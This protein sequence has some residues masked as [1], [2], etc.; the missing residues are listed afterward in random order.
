MGEEWLTKLIALLSKAG[1]A[2]G[3]EYAS[4]PVQAIS[5]PVAAVGMQGLDW[6]EGT[7]RFLV[8][9]LSPRTRGGWACQTTAAKAVTAMEDGHI[10]ARMEEMTYLPGCDCFEVRVIGQMQVRTIS[11]DAPAPRGWDVTVQGK[12]LEWVTEFE[13]DRDLNRRLIGAMGESMPG[14]VTPGCGAWNIRLVQK[15]PAGEE[16]TMQVLAEPF[17]LTAVRGSRQIQYRN[18]CWNRSR[19]KLSGENL[20]VERWGFALER[21]VMPV[22][23]A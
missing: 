10:H 6:A 4:A 20:L 9:I 11:P 8:R 21:E 14:A 3:E 22:E 2:A 12:P 16:D 1:I 23:P 7:A 17:A 13:E 15:I 5:Q 18:C 19:R